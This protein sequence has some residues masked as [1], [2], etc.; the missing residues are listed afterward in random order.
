MAENLTNK[1]IYET[2]HGI[3]KTGDNL[4]LDNTLKVLSDGDGN[5]LPIFVSADEIKFK[6]GSSV[7]FTDTTI[8]GAAGFQGPQGTQGIAGPQGSEGDQGIAGPQGI[9]GSQGSKGDQGIAGPQGPK[10]NQGVAGPQGSKGDQGNV[11]SQG[12]A[13]PQGFKGDQGLQGNQGDQGDQGPQGDQGDQRPQGDQGIEGPQGSKGNQGIAGPQGTQGNIGSQGY[14]GNVGSQGSQGQIGSQGNQGNIG[15]QGNQGPQGIVGPQGLKGDQGYQ[16]DIGPQG[17]TGVNAGSIY[18]MNQ[19]VNSDIIGY[20]KLAVDPIISPEVIVNTTVA[21]NTANVLVTSFMTPEL[22]F[23][24]IPAGIQNFHLHFLKPAINDKVNAYCTIELANSAGIGYGTIL[25]SAIE[26]IG[27]NLGLPYSIQSL[28]T[29]VTTTI[30]PTDR[31]I[32]KVYLNNLDSTQHIV[33]FYTEGSAYYSFVQTSTQAIGSQGPQGN[34]G[35]QGNQGNVGPQ[36][37]QGNQGIAGSQ[38]FKGDQGIAG[39]QGN[40]GNQGN[41]GPQGIQGNQG[42]Q[43][44]QGYQGPTNPNNIVSSG[45]NTIANIW[46]GTLAQYTALGSYSATT[47]YF[48]E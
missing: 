30:N 17:I 2:Y 19:S 7:D 33:G 24:V 4:P 34:V 16:G 3:I 21:G 43:G 11:G 48:I 38:G 20:K 18:Y 12:I 26:V 22:G 27:W 10:G 39:P 45:P 42:P 46:S 9:A 14:Q 25:Q 31:M 1:H 6:E 41:A 13:G 47:L 5:E 36:G 40:Q 35:P 29:L 28:L 32:V 8:I 15:S 23:S 44:Y 37:S